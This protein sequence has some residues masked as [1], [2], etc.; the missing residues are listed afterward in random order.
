MIDKSTS[1]TIPF[2]V[3]IA[4][5]EDR[6][7]LIIIIEQAAILIRLKLLF[8]YMTYVFKLTLAIQLLSR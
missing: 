6:V 1:L 2:V 5:E 7:A 4:L 8:V 3:L